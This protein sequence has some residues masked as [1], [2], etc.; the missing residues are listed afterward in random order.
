MLFVAGLLQHLATENFVHVGLVLF[1]LRPEPSQNVG[2]DPQAHLLLL[3]T[4]DVH[5]FWMGGHRRNVGIV[6]FRIGLRH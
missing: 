4:P 1:A 3:W 6:D 5:C 2:I